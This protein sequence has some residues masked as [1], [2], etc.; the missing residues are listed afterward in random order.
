MNKR[1]L[2]KIANVIIV[3]GV[4]VALYP[5]LDRAFT[6][7]WQQKVFNDWEES[8]AA[9][10]D[11]LDDSHYAPVTGSEPGSE[12]HEETW[13]D[14]ESTE[15]PSGGL[16]ALEPLGMLEIEKIDLKK[17][18]FKGSGILNL[19]I[20]AGLLENTAEIGAPGNTVLTAHRSYTYGRFFNRL[21]EMQAG[22]EVVIATPEG[23]YRYVAYNKVI[24]EPDDTSVTRGSKEEKILTLYT[25]HPIHNATHRL[26]VQA[27]LIEEAEGENTEEAG[28]ADEGNAEKAGEGNA[29]EAKKGITEEADKAAGDVGSVEG[30][31]KAGDAEDADD[32]GETEEV[33]EADGT[34]EVDEVD[35]EKNDD[36]ADKDNC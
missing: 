28:E 6:W 14:T 5:L 13:G 12:P 8:L 26:I 1:T 9:E 32:A 11:F 34:D 21:D 20:G 33:D 31:G 27:K 17:P 29:D 3:A 22:D 23:T 10:E 2:A 35:E 7:Y 30:A 18:V 15:E 25:C 16:F 36:H 19:K 4:L 24:V